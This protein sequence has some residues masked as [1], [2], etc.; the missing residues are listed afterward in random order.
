MGSLNSPKGTLLQGVDVRDRK[1]KARYNKGDNHFK[2]SA[3]WGRER[4]SWIGEGKKGDEGR[5]G[6]RGSSGYKHCGARHKRSPK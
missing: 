2:W 3:R 1:A 4:V 5:G 6:W